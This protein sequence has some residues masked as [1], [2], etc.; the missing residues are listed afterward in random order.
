MDVVL[1]SSRGKGLEALIR[2]KHPSPDHLIM[3]STSSAKLHI[4]TSQALELISKSPNPSNHHIYII[5]GYCDLSEIIHHKLTT[6][7]RA[8]YQEAVFRE[9]PG[10]AAA[11]LTS[12]FETTS[13]TISINHAKPILC[14]IP[15]SSIHNWNHT[16]LRQHKTALLKHCKQ[17]PTM[18]ENMIQSLL[19]INTNIIGINKSHGTYTPKLADAIITKSGGKITGFTT[20]GW[21]T[22]CTRHSPWRRSGQI[23][24]SKPLTKIAHHSPH[25]AWNL[26]PV[27]LHRILTPTPTLN[28]ITRERKGNGCTRK[29]K[30]KKKKN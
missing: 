12:L 11:R 16:R 23:W 22:G 18:Q 15:P 25:L 14:T 8:Q 13:R 27:L 5:G 30:K 24:F 20:V 9:E 26:F 10:A 29:T 19:I 7:Y 1:A 28:M 21:W 2:S 4:L 6:H 17:Y 3:K